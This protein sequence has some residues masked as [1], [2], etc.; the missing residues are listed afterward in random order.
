MRDAIA[1]LNYIQ[2][3]VVTVAGFMLGWLWYGVLFGRM[4]MAEMK[5]TPE[6]AAAEKGNMAGYFAKG[7]LFTFLSTFGLAVLIAAHGVPNWKHGAACGLFIGGFVA[8]M[9]KLNDAVWEKRSLR[10]Q[11]ISFGHELVVYAVQG[12]I[13]G[14]W[15]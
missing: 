5:I 7:L 3:L 14:A 15:H 9:R 2:V 13:L 4:W 6:M 11:A 8:G 1:H 12:A 10:F